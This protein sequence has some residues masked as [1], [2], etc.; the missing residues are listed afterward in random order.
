M[1]IKSFLFNGYKV[2]IVHGVRYAFVLLTPD[3]FGCMKDERNQRPRARQN[4]ILIL[5]A[6]WG[7]IKSVVYVQRIQKYRLITVAWF[8]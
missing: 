1:G 4:V 5:G 2:F 3:D 6:G 8:I 7:V